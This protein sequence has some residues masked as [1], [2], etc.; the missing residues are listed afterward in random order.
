MNTAPFDSINLDNGM[1]TMNDVT[2]Q[3]SG[4]YS[5]LRPRCGGSY[6]GLVDLQSDL[7]IGTMLNGN[8]YLAFTTGNILSND[9]DMEGIWANLYTGIMQ[10]NYFI[11]KVGEFKAAND[12][13][14]DDLL[15]VNK[16]DA[17]AHFMRAYYNYLLMNYYCGAYDPT[18]ADK[19]ATGIPLVTVYDPSGNRGTYVGR[20]TLNETYTAIEG[21]MTIAYNGLAAYEKASGDVELGTGYLNSYAVEALQARVALLKEDW[22]TAFDKSNDVI[23]SGLFDLCEREDYYDM[24]YIDEGSEL[25]FS[26]FANAAQMSS[27]PAAGTIFNQSNPS[28][29]KFAPSGALISSYAEEDVRRE[30]F[31][32][33]LDVDY[34]GSTLLVPSFNKY[35]G[36]VTFNSGNSNA[37]KNLPKPFRTSEQYLI[38]AEA[39]YRLSKPD[40]ANKKLADLRKARIEDYTATD[41]NGNTLFEQIKMERAKELVGEGFR[42]SDLRRWKQGFTRDGAYPDYPDMSGFIINIALEVVYTGDDY[43]YTWPIPSYEMT[44]NPQLKGQQNP[45]YDNN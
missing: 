27:V 14:E 16:Y 39:A 9:G 3:R 30:A 33:D 26:P 35:P 45:G 21:D 10:V 36:N 34:S 25:I 23:N 4:L 18:T 22:Q 37:Y 2:A 40:V 8:N 1:S 11:G 7:F 32:F 38:N 12:L 28:A 19:A 41:Y 29:V 42:I 15:L 13:S 44:T 17:E 43:R 31:I 5:Y 6:T 24:W 20:S